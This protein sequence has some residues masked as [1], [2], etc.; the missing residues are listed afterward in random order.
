MRI[1]TGS[2]PIFQTL[3]TENDEILFNM[4]LMIRDDPKARLFTDDRHF[5]LAQ[6]NEKTPVWLWLSHDPDESA[7]SDVTQLLLDALQRN[8]DV[9]INADPSRVK[10][11]FPALLNAGIRLDTHMT[12]NAY[13]CRNLHMLPAKGVC[14]PVSPAYRDDIASLYRQ[15]TEDA[16]GIV[17]PP[18]TALAFADKVSRSPWLYLW[19]DGGIAAMAMV[20]HRTDRYARINTV[21]TD[22]SRRGCGY[23]GMLVGCICRDLMTNGVTPMLYADADYPSSN[24]AYRKIGFEL[25]GQ[26]VEYRAAGC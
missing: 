4:F 18:E 21:A 25:C 24:R 13:V 3:L 22:R 15:F 17:I 7:L 19:D 26:I 12:L 10:P 8:P 16:E 5:I 1:I 20:R 6:S 14:I 2:D 11:L 23:A 9:H